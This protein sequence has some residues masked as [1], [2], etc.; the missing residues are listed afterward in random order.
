M[1]YSA[2]SL[3][4]SPVNTGLSNPNDL[5]TKAEIV[6]AIA[7]D[8]VVVVVALGLASSSVVGPPLL[9]SSFSGFFSICSIVSIERTVLFCQ[10]R[11]NESS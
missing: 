3:A 8:A 4:A 10:K 6:V 5:V 7:D 9:A 11:N 2:R 1:P